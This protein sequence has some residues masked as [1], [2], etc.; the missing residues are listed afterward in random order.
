MTFTTKYLPTI[1]V[2]IIGWIC[3]TKLENFT[4][5]MN[6]QISQK[7]AYKENLRKDPDWENIL[8][9]TSSPKNC[10]I[11]HWVEIEQSWREVSIPVHL[12]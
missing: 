6:S 12:H 11:V 10:I 2:N 1:L 8:I 3:A 4:L 9:F 7:K 5:N